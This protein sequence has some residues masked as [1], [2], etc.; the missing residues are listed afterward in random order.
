MVNDEE[1]WKTYPDYHFIEASNLGRVRTVDRIVNSKNGREYHIKGRV[2]KQHLQKNGYMSVSFRMCGKKVLLLVHRIIAACFCPN[3]NNYPQVNHKDNDRTNNV[4]DNLEWCTLEYN[5]AY[6]E[7]YGIACSRP[8]FA[9][10]LK[11]GKVFWFES[12]M[13]ASR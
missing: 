7:K 4:A 12:Q 3:P 13:E 8:V 9:V 11:T 10:D 6:R 5:I 2:L 1:I